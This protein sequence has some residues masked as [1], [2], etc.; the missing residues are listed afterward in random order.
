[1]M[2]LASTRSA[3][4]ARA[5]S[6]LVSVLVL[7]ASGEAFAQ[8]TSPAAKPAP[9]KGSKGDQKKK[10]ETKQ[11]TTTET[12]AT[13]MG[14]KTN[15]PVETPKAEPEEKEATR[16]IYVSGDLGFTR[17][18]LGALSN[19]LAFDK[20]AANGVAWSFAAGLRLKDFKVGAR[21]RVWDTT[22][23]DL[24]SFM[25]EG[26]YSMPLR[27]VSPGI[28]AHVGYVWDQSL[29]R[30][31]YASS[32]PGNRQTVLDP[33]VD[34]HGLVAGVEGQAMY[35]VS[36]YVRVG[37]FVG[38]DLLF[39]SRPAAGL[40]GSVF[41]LTSDITSKPLYTEDGSGIGYTFNVG[42][43]GAFDVGF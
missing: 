13:A 32:I 9:A 40:P 33:N 6:V 36:K 18:D 41:P 43:R 31:L 16:A 14:A 29:Q 17:V 23:F 25:L 10:E 19:S 7:G 42:L 22:E 37:A 39:L 21:W 28:M 24:W 34:V 35:W 15:A 26:G 2:R 27:P 12:E 1:M 3:V 30:P 20:T 4:S 38:F 8:A 11:T 5:L